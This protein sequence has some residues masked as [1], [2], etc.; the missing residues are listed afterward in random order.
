[1]A[2]FNESFVVLWT[3]LNWKN[4]QR[5]NRLSWNKGEADDAGRFDSFPHPEA[6]S[7]HLQACLNVTPQGPPGRMTLST[8]SS[9]CSK[10][11]C[12]CRGRN[13]GCGGTGQ[14]AVQ[15]ES[16]E[17]G[18]ERGR[19]LSERIRKRLI[20]GF[21]AFPSCS[22][23]QFRAASLG[24]SAPGSV[25]NDL[26]NVYINDLSVYSQGEWPKALNLKSLKCFYLYF[27]DIRCSR[28]R[29]NV[30]VLRQPLNILDE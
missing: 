15:G 10:G 27:C 28:D 2:K 26:G 22:A 30:G 7:L 25:Y 11:K 8:L 9:D 19:C 12:H 1:M 6:V 16:T 14:G 29:G 4:K 17:R 18:T 13:Y 5:L 20:H 21:F 24:T 23:M 3:F